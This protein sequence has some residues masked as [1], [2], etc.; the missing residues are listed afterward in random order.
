M[1]IRVTIGSR[2]YEELRTSGS[3]GQTDVDLK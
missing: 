3:G 2:R 1:E